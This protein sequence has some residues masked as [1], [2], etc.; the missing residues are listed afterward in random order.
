M[1]LFR[2]MIVAGLFLTISAYAQTGGFGLG[3]IVGEPTGL[4]GKYYLSESHAI[5]GAVAW[6]FKKDAAL[7]IHADYLYHDNS[8][9]NVTK[10]RLPL[11]VGIGGRIKLQ[12]KSRI[13]VRVPVGIAYEFPK[14]PVD[15]FVEIVPLLD[16]IPDTQFDFNGAIGVR[17]YFH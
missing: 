16:I 4:S 11:Y 9:L 8:F 17:Y 6:S 7:H 1:K 12:D 3:I 10:G 14:A 5:D 15:V 2:S 13:G